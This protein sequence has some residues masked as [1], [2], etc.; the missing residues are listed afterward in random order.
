MISNGVINLAPDKEAVFAEAA[1]VL[2]PG[3]RLAIAD[4]VS[5]QQLKES[6]VCDADLWAACIGGAAQ[7][8]AYRQAIEGAGLRI[9]EIQREPLRVHLRPRPRRQRQVRGQERLAAGAK[10]AV[11]MPRNGRVIVGCTHG[12]EDPDRVGGL[13][14]SPPAPP[15][16]RGKAGRDVRPAVEARPLDR[17]IDNGDALARMRV[18]PVPARALAPKPPRDPN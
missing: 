12:E 3:G 5:E 14:T 13:R 15:S 10:G 8:D 7:E 1:R 11:D 18:K 9:E 6:I 2:R 4:I 17:F 16:T